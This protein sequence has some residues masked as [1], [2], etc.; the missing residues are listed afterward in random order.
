MID[1]LIKRFN[2][3]CRSHSHR[4]NTMSTITTT[5]SDSSR[6]GQC[7]R[8]KFPLSPILVLVPEHLLDVTLEAAAAVNAR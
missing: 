7:D 4:H 6:G 1:E 5:G 3:R 8:D 2:S